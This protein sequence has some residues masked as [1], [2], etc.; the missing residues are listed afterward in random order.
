MMMPTPGCQ[1]VRIVEP[2]RMLKSIPG[3]RT[4][5]QV[6][7]ITFSD[8]RPDEEKIVVWQRP[9]L[10]S[11]GGV[12]RLRKLLRR[13]YLVVVDCDDDPFRRHE[14]RLND[15][16]PLRGCH[17][18]QTSTDALAD[19][20]REFNPHV[21]VFEN[22]LAELPPPPEY[23]EGDV[24]VRIF[25]GAIAREYDWAPLVPELHAVIESRGE[26]IEFQVLHD[27]RFF[28]ALPTAAKSFDKLARYER[29]LELLAEADVAILPLA[30]TRKNRLKS[31]L[32]F[33][34]C[35][36]RGVAVL[37]SPVVY[38]STIEDGSTGMIFRSPAEFGQ[39]LLSLVDDPALRRRLGE[40]AY[41]YVRDNRL[42]S[43]HFRKRYEWYI[44]LRSRLPELTRDLARRV[45][46]LA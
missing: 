23:C 5:A 2:N 44:Q 35:A 38:E 11:R 36:S 1:H 9:L 18:I 25:F 37:A 28:E 17:A 4:L 43:Q 13:G 42:L 39:K 6:N 16:L 45:G 32:K 40:A 12:E 29:Y 30:D 7:S 19:V 31:D 22:Q 24:P 20:L 21:A 33:I 8:A 34:E 26:R 14:H 10:D 3:V 15:F 27:Q 46:E 41:A